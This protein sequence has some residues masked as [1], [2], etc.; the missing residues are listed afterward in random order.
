MTNCH[1]R[2]THPEE[3]NFAG[4]MPSLRKDVADRHELVRCGGAA[5][6]EHPALFHAKPALFRPDTLLPLIEYISN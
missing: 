3:R 5:P 4:A 2:K 1:G 6:T